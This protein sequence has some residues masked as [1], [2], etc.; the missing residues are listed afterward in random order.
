MAGVSVLNQ[1]GVCFHLANIKHEIKLQHLVK[2][3]VCLSD[4]HEM[5]FPILSPAKQTAV[6]LVCSG[7]LRALQ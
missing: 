5:T 2:A 6:D 4:A 7:Q 3:Q 1:S